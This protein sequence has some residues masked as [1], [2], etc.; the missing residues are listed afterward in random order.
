M[1]TSQSTRREFL[2][3]IGALTGAFGLLAQAPPA[4]AAD[5]SPNIV[6]ILADDLG[7]GD[8]KALNPECKIK[9]PNLDRLARGGKIFTDAHSSSSVCTPTRY[10]LLTGR[11]N[12]RSRLKS[13]VLWGY[14]RRLIEPDRL[15]LGG[16]LQQRGYHTA[17]IGKWH[18]G[19]DWTLKDGGVAEQAEASTGQALGW[20]IDY[21]APIRNGPNSA[22]FDYFHGISASLDMRPYMFIENDRALFT[23]V[24]EKGFNRL[25]AADVDFEAIDVLPRITEKCVD[26]I[27]QRAKQKGPFFVYFPLNAPHTPIL[28]T[29]E[30]QGKSGI[31]KYCDFVM[32]VDWTVGQVMQALDRNGVAENTLIIF[33]SDNGCSPAAKIPEMQ[34]A[35]H[36]PSHIYR[37]HKADIFE[38]GHR[39]PFIARWPQ[40][41]GPGT[42][43]DQLVCL[44]DIMATCAD[45]VGVKLPGNAAEDSVSMLPALLGE[46][47]GPLREA[48]VHHSIN[49]SFSIRQ[50]NWKLELCPGSGGWSFPRPGRDDQTGLP[51]IQLYDLGAD[52]GETNNL[53]AEHPEVVKRLTA[54]L[55][56]YVRDGRS[57]PGPKQSN[58]G[59]VKIQLS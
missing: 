46:D 48:A 47:E 28:P 31:N 9:T 8:V 6:V 59:E 57:T 19:Q 33:T 7:Y 52:P 41:I 24:V 14:S 34:A 39:I 22:G 2:K 32:Q 25:G 4:G 42:K 56:K 40:H 36:Y 49:G 20:E 15:T 23:K 44:T 43:S 1:Q 21:K 45:I 58:N 26:Y 37:G 18:L 30:W 16:M 35:G 5:T 3:T 54:L 38:G 11:Y 29:P 27:D 53:Q 13:G 10:G 12:W 55:E 50:E 17:C 51:S